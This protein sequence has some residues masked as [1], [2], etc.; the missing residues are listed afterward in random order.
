[1]NAQHPS[2]TDIVGLCVF[3][4]TLL[5][6]AEVAEVVGPYLVIITAS[7][8]GASFSLKR[9]EK[10]TRTSAILFFLRVCG[11]AA[12]LTVGVSAMVAGYYPSLTERVLLAPVAFIVGLVGDDWPAIGWWVVAKVSTFIDVLIKLKGGSQ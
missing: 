5:F 8:I 4:A 12:L 6:S 9:R 2:I 1:M 3:I 7:A 10:S 11:L